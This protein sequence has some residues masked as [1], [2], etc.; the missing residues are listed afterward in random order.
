MY[1]PRSDPQ[2]VGDI[3]RRG[4]GGSRVYPGG[5]LARIS[6]QGMGDIRKAWA[7]TAHPP[8]LYVA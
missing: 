1:L 6:T 5:G 7:L 2:G 8:T 4:Q 3:H